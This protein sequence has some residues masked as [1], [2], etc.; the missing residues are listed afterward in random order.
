MK[1][2]ELFTIRN[3]TKSKLPRLPFVYIKEKILGKKYDL[4]VSFLSSVKQKEINSK[5]RGINKTTNILSFPISKNSGEITFDLLKVKKDA[6]LFDMKYSVFLK[7]LFIHGCL[8]LKGFDHGS[9]MEKQ[10]KKYMK[11]FS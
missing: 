9:I 3:T 7:F 8:H 5:Y 6:P 1:E 11:I 10:E 2:T 4:S